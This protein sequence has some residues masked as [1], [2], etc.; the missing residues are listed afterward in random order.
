MLKKGHH[1]NEHENVLLSDLN[2]SQQPQ[3]LF[4]APYTALKCVYLNEEFFKAFLIKLHIYF[5]KSKKN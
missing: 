4:I 5:E 2:S 3:S 1:I